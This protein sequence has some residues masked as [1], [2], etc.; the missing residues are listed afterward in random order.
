MLV[1]CFL[2]SSSF[3]FKPSPQS[4]SHRYK[5]LRRLP[6][7]RMRH[8][9]QYSPLRYQANRKC[10]G[11]LCCEL[12]YYL[13]KW[14]D[15]L[16]PISTM[17]HQATLCTPPGREKETASRQTTATFDQRALSVRDRLCSK[18]THKSGYTKRDLL[19]TVFGF[20]TYK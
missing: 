10:W 19:F 15:A 3:H 13:L 2:P 20:H 1:V 7:G 12:A 4:P 11:G 17:P 14:H 16:L 6:E 8:V 5:A 9:I 18:I